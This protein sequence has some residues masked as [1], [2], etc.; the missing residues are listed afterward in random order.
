MRGYE[1]GFEGGFE[2]GFEGGDEVALQQAK[3]EQSQGHGKIATGSFANSPN[4]SAQGIGI[5][6]KSIIALLE[7]GEADEELQK[8]VKLDE[9]DTINKFNYVSRKGQRN[10]MKKL[11][12]MMANGTYDALPTFEKYAAAQGD[13]GS[14]LSGGG[15]KSGGGGVSDGSAKVSGSSG[16]CIIA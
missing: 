7:E 14:I 8:K 11:V 2:A 13:A 15:E 12:D 16:C 6:A 3:E 10:G 1:G 9:K 5:N 4:Q